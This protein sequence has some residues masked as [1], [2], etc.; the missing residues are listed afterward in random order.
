MILPYYVS[1]RVIRHNLS[2]PFIREEVG[3][4]IAKL[5]AALEKAV[6]KT[7][8]LTHVVF[9]THERAQQMEDAATT[10][11][12][13][14]AQTNACLERLLMDI[15][16]EVSTMRSNIELAN[17]RAEEAKKAGENSQSQQLNVANKLR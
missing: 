4:A 9:E 2:N 13:G 1:R 17:R 5:H 8:K 7:K 14:L 11:A 10:N 12:E 6:K 3:V 15:H 16:A